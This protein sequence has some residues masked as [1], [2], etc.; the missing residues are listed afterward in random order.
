MLATAALAIIGV[1]NHDPPN[2]SRSVVPSNIGKSLPH[3]TAQHV[4]ALPGNAGESIDGAHEHV[5]AEPVEMT[6]IAQP[7]TSRRDMVGRRLALRFDQHRHVHK[8][9]TVPRRPRLQPLQTFA[10]RIDRQ[11]ISRPSSGGA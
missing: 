3:L 8:I 9:A 4:P 11:T 1:A 10:P 7:R 5:V 6:P 2:P